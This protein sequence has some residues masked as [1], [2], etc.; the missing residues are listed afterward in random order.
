MIVP[1]ISKRKKKEIEAWIST[2]T[3]SERRRVMQKI[4]AI[5]DWCQFLLSLTPPP[6]FVPYDD[7]LESRHMKD[8]LN[9]KLGNRNDRGDIFEEVK[10]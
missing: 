2:L 7:E 4:K 6:P 10:R 5:G 3:D 8:F 1:T 9:E